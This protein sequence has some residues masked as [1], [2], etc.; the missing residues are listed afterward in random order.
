M[1]F[2]ACFLFVLYSLSMNISLFHLMV[3]Y[4][5][6]LEIAKLRWPLKIIPICLENMLPY[7]HVDMELLWRKLSM[8]WCQEELNLKLTSNFTFY[9][10]PLA[11]DSSWCLLLWYMIFPSPSKLFSKGEHGLYI[12]VWKLE[13]MH[14]YQ[15]HGLHFLYTFQICPDVS[16]LDHFLSN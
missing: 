2:L 16:S 15:M 9:L 5:F 11:Y 14:H 1:L 12:C 6:L 3:L 13:L 8:F 10:L 4:I 7:I